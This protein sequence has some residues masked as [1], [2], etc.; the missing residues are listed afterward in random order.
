MVSMDLL[1]E[2]GRR[3]NRAGALLLPMLCVCF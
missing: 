1:V 3:T 2:G